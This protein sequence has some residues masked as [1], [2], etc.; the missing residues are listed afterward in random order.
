M[1]WP[2]LLRAVFALALTLG[3]V[4]LAAWAG[5]RWGPS[6]L[7][8]S[9]ARPAAQKRLAVVESLN[10]SPTQRL[11]LVTVDG[12][13]RLVL[14]GDGRLYEARH[15]PSPATPPHPASPPPAGRSASDV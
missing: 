10:L 13:E 6:T 3:L 11:V 2:S 1:D 14:L 4:G 5:R 8:A 9:A 7:F 12:A 15:A